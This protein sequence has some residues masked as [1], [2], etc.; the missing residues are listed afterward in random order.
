MAYMTMDPSTATIPGTSAAANPSG[1]DTLADLSTKA[2]EPLSAVPNLSTIRENQKKDQQLPD[3]LNSDDIGSLAGDAVN[4]N[5]DKDTSPIPLAKPSE[6]I[7]TTLSESMPKNANKN[8]SS[9]SSSCSGTMPDP[10][11]LNATSTVL[12]VDKPGNDSSPTTA[13]AP[14]SRP[15]TDASSTNDNSN[16]HSRNL[17]GQA[18]N[19]AD[20]SAFTYRLTTSVSLVSTV[21]A[22]FIWMLV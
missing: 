11:A 14:G 15:S 19:V 6:L 21:L 7:N 10:N 2:D 20:N 1:V 9:S 13:V 4:D 16:D 22:T 5:E 8:H 17:V 18:P 3:S 12:A